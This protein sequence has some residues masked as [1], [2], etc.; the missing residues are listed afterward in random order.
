M[1]QPLQTDLKPSKVTQLVTL[2]RD[3][4][5]ACAP[6]PGFMKTWS[7]TALAGWGGMAQRRVKG[8]RRQHPFRRES[9]NGDLGP[10]CK[11]GDAVA[12]EM[13]RLVH[14]DRLIPG[15]ATARQGN[16]PGRALGVRQG[17]WSWR[18]QWAVVFP[19]TYS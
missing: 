19:R 3:T 5:R 11:H 2:L 15:G 10:K 7:I 18:C 16:P 8:Q 17:T 12:A 13:G 9:W 14:M 6:T 4:A 1:A